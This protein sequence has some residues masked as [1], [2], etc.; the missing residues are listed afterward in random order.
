MEEQG[1]AM[2]LERVLGFV[3]TS[4]KEPRRQTSHWNYDHG[5]SSMP[6]YR[7]SAFASSAS[8]RS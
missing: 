1:A 6:A 8:C 4:V 7:R 5:E 2:G 3:E